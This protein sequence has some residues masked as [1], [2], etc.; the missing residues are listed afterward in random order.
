MGVVLKFKELKPYRKE[1]KDHESKTSI[2]FYCF[3]NA[4]VSDTHA[5]CIF[6]Q[7]YPDRPIQIVIPNVA[8]S[9]MDI[10]GRM[11]AA[12]LEKILN[13]NIIPNNKPGA[14]TALGT[15]LVVRGKKD[16]YTLL[17]GD[18]HSALII[19]PITNPELIHYDPSKDVEPLGFHFLFPK[20]PDGQI[21]FPLENLPELVA[22]GNKNP[23]KLRVSTM[24]V[25]SLPHLLLEILQATT[26]T[27]FT[28][29]P[30]KGGESVVTALLGG[31]CGSHL[32]L[33]SRGKPT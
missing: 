6:A 17:Y 22:Y 19:A 23:G 10:G 32:P 25:G 4:G 27:Q 16:G 21:R 13:A 12:E 31:P 11:I 30:F 2:I 8:G 29:I 26:G 9:S 3:I 15:E 28:H 14:G 1:G 5:L 33:F 20:H 18:L 7:H 24:G